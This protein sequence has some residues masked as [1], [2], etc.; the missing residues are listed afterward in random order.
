MKTTLLITLLLTATYTLT[1][2]ST[3]SGIGETSS[4]SSYEEGVPGGTFV[5]T[6]TA[7]ATVAALDAKNREVTLVDANGKEETIKCGPEVVNF[8]QI[9][10]GDSV[11]V[12]MNSV[13]V[14][15]MV[16][17]DSTPAEAAVTQVSLAP[18]GDKPGGSVTE[19]QQ[20]T[21]TIS[22]INVKRQEATLSFPGGTTRTFAVRK[23][24][25]LSERKVGERVVVLVQVA[26]TI[27][28]EEP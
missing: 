5:E 8:D 14:L 7:E 22:D 18:L 17:E 4:L 10:V 1:S 26:V 28:V 15:G 23:D 24:V 3:S 12:T 20:Y 2:C 25:D 19:T 13:L 27:S 9:K 11:T 6:Y 16:D 21:A